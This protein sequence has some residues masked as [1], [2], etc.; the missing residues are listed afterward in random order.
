MVVNM[1]KSELDAARAFLK[2]CAELYP[3]LD[4]MDEATQSSYYRS[5]LI[6]K[7]AEL[8]QRRQ[9]YREEQLAQEA[10]QQE[11]QRPTKPKK[12]GKLAQYEEDVIECLRQGFGEEKQLLEEAYAR[13]NKWARINYVKAYYRAVDRFNRGRA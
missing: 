3:E 7:Q 8:E 4:L 10:E 13:K 6:V 12:K 1:N 2:T 9:E 5:Y 11:A